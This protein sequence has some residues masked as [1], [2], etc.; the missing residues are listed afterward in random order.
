MRLIKISTTLPVWAYCITA[1]ILS[2]CAHSG[3]VSIGPG[4]YMIA[5]SEWGFTSGG[6]QKAKVM[7]EASDYCKSIGK[8]M[9]GALKN[10]VQHLWERMLHE[11]NLQAFEY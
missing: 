4:T 6:V 3:V 10:Q 1:A 8:Q 2:A 7:K 11:K 5:N 9:L